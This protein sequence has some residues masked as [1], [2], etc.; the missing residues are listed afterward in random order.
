MILDDLNVLLGK[1]SESDDVLNIYI[2]RAITSIKNYLDSE[3]YTPTYIEENF[4]DA[5]VEMAY[6]SFMSKGKENVSSEKYGTT[7]KSYRVT[8]TIKDLLPLPSMHL[9]G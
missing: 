4:Q 8:N 5:I 3:T 9:L 6:N 7:S 2:R 1:N